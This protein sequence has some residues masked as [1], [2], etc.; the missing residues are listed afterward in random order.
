MD[1]KQP[2]AYDAHAKEKELQNE[3]LQWETSDPK[4]GTPKDIPIIDVAKYLEDTSEETELRRLGEQLRWACENVG[5]YQLVGH[6]LS[7]E[8]TEE[9]LEE[10]R[11]FHALPE[12]VKTKIRMDRPE[13]PIYLGY[14]NHKLP[15]RATPNSNAAFL[16]KSD[17]RIDLIRHNQ[18]PEEA[19]LPDF[20]YRVRDY[21]KTI[22]TLAKKLLPIY[23]SAL[24]LPANYVDKAFD[25]PFYRLR[26]SH[27]PGMP[28]Q[29]TSSSFGIAPHV[30]T[31]F[32]T[33][34][35]TDGSPGLCLF[36]HPRNEWIQMPALAATNALI[37]N[38]GELLRQYSNDTFLSVRHFV[39][40]GETER[41]SVPFFFNANS[42]YRIECF[43]TCCSDDN[44]PK[45]PPFSYNESQGVVQGE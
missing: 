7:I 15:T 16:V 42:D 32:F 10:T 12:H 5:F 9:I 3:S 39:R 11:R 37:V 40:N 29:S 20:Q 43:P 6:G 33:L 30:D 36:S 2:S 19:E 8:C 25:E 34:L 4:P 45:Y 23:A 22:T 1:P 26:M 41:Y 28:Q 17:H 24:H 13:H 35:L 27:Y 31:S 21:A 14:R 38:S 44:P 18:W